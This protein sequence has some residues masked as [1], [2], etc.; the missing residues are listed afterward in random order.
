MKRVILSSS[1]SGNVGIWWYTP[2]KVV[3]G[4]LVP[5]TEGEVSGNYIQ[6]SN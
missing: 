2:Q 3:W 4:K 5:T 1:M 6:F